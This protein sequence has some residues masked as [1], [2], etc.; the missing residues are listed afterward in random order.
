MKN[1]E[2]TMKFSRYLFLIFI[3]AVLGLCVIPSA[4]AENPTPM[5]TPV[6]AVNTPQGIAV[7][8]STGVDSQPLL[9]ATMTIVPTVS[10][11]PQW[12]QDLITT[13]EK[14]PLVGPYV[15]KALLY[16]GILSAILTSLTACIMGILSILMGVSN[17]ARLTNVSTFLANFRDGKFMYWIKFFSLFNAQKPGDS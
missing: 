11:P 14:L 2:E 7:P 10:A 15:A 8:V 13:A 1:L 4:F 6:I 17:A 9:P 5:S 16:L 3:L 12:A